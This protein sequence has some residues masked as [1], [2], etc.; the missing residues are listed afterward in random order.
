M[1]TTFF[2]FATSS[3]HLS[4]ALEILCK[5]SNTGARNFFCYW[6]SSTH[7]PGR[8]S[9]QYESYF[10]RTPRKV[11]Q[12]A[13]CADPNV[14]I[15]KEMQYDG[16]W[17]NLAIK[18]FLNQFTTV[19]TLRDLENLNFDGV[20]PGSALANELATISKDRDFN[21]KANMP[22]VCTLLRSYLEVFS[23]AGEFIS[24]NSISR[25]YVFNGRF[26]HERAIWDSAKKRGVECIL[27]ETMRDR[28]LTRG[29]GFHDR[30]NN[31]LEM[32][33]VWEHSGLNEVEKVAIGSEYF[34][35]LRSRANPFATSGEL[36]FENE[37]PYFVYFSNSDDE[38]IGFWNSW[39]ETFGVQ[40]QAIKTLQELFDQL[41]DKHLV[42]RLHPNLS[43]KSSK[44]KTDWSEI[45]ATKNSTVI[46]Y[47]SKISSYQLLDECLGSITFGSTLGL[48]SAYSGKPTLLL[49]DSGYD[50]LGVA[51]K[52]TEWSQVAN[53]ILKD[54]SLEEQELTNRQIRACIRGFFLAKGGVSFEYCEL[55]EVGWGA[56]RVVKFNG[57]KLK[58]NFFTHTYS[59]FISKLKFLK[60]QVRVKHG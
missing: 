21:F 1:N 43:N 4:A 29:K 50:I 3:I 9:N 51:D 57:I 10:R 34:N 48:E 33:H 56:W 11:K 49:A 30:I 17:V 41:D 28:Y 24:M 5:E 6:G 44:Q 18:E 59:K 45:R 8:M 32:L 40:I 20:K 42:I 27:F 13:R 46:S 35:Q 54:Y 53:W 25:V 31:Q 14:V 15:N 23:A 2:Q 58:S 39:N 37:K 38:A 16:T 36:R 55:R 7:F 22:L 19:F 60:V 47:D 26:L 12:L 52:P